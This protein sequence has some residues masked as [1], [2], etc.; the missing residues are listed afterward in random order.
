MEHFTFFVNLSRSMTAGFTVCYYECLLIIIDEAV[1]SPNIINLIWVK[2][3][4]GV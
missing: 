3:W 2:I 1:M 4:A